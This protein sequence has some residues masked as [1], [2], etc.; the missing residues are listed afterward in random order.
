MKEEIKNYRKNHNDL[1]FGQD[2]WN[3]MAKA[4][5]WNSPEANALFYIEDKDLA[6][7]LDSK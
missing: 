2:L 4:G 7:L 5:Y 1:R 3:K 6:D